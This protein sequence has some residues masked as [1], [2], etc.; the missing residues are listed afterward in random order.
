MTRQASRDL[1]LARLIALSQDQRR[2]LLNALTAAQRR[3]LNNRW[4][5]WAHDGQAWPE[6]DWRVWLIRAGRGFG[7][8]RAGAEWVSQ[9]AR[10][11][12]D[13]VIALVGATME[14]ARRVMV[15]GPSGLLAVAHNDERPVFRRALGEVHFESGA[16]ALLYSSEAPEKLRGP[17]HAAAWCDELGKWRHDRGEMAWDNLMLTMRSTEAAR[18]LVTTTPRPTKL[19]RKVMALPGLVETRGKTRDNAHL[20][21]SFVSAM[22]SEYG[23]T[24]LGRQELDGEIVDDVENAL[25][26][27]ALI[28]RQRVREAPAL[29]RIVVGVDPPASSQGDACGIV[30]VGIADDGALY[31][32]EDA[33]VRTPSPEQWANAVANCF[34]RHAADQVIAE[35]NQG[36]DMVGSTLRAAE[37]TLPVRLVSATRGKAVRAEPIALLYAR[38]RMFHAGRFPM[39]ED[40]LCGMQTGGDY[41]GPHRSP[42]RA[43]A[44]VWAAAA[45]LEG[46]RRKTQI[47]HL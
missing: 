29:R 43:D 11:Q 32:I 22:L 46:M 24:S 2:T 15:E 17:E 25:W 12:K 40:E 45:L 34:A 38:G 14:D 27:R 47:R 8:T 37:A 19:M 26:T 21:E 23:G 1:M 31:V 13:A 42:D 3:E 18:I 28:E 6:S 5:L 44:M 7:K 16:K 33:S 20:P 10:D 9:I 41:H 39:L 30:A 35:K 4:W 36:G